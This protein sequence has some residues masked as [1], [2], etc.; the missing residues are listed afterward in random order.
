MH[1]FVYEP[2]T[3]EATKLPVNFTDYLKGLGNVYDL[4]TLQN[5]D[6]PSVSDAVAQTNKEQTAAALVA[7]SN[8]EE[9]KALHDFIDHFPSHSKDG[10][11]LPGQ[12]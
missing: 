2:T 12:V 7:S 11:L 3:G 6:V 9:E 10:R 1:A 4:Y 5:H 8:D